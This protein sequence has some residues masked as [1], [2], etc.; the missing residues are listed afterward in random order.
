MKKSFTVWY[1]FCKKECRCQYCNYDDQVDHYLKGL[2]GCKQLENAH[3]PHD[4][5]HYRKQVLDDECPCL[6]DLKGGMFIQG[7]NDVLHAIEPCEYYALN[8]YQNQ[9]SE[10]VYE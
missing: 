7:R 8:A 10:L 4:D 6:S 1:H 9:N 2:C 5:Q 3:S